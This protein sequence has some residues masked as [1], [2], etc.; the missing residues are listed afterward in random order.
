MP[1]LSQMAS[2]S[3]AI[4]AAIFGRPFVCTMSGESGFSCAEDVA[5]AFIGC[6][7]ANVQGCP[8]FNIRG[9][10]TTAEHFIAQCASH[11]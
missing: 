5:R 10:V 3:Q 9:E 8:V 11:K 4:K 1:S 7:F 6:C 2:C